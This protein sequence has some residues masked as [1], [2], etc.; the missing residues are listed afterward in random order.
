MEGGFR[1]SGFAAKKKKCFKAKET[2]QN[3][4]IITAAAHM[5]HR[6]AWQPYA[7]ELR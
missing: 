4:S 1:V 5:R 6:I 7:Q 2:M 3:T